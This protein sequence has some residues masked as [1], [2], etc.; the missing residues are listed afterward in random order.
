MGILN[1]FSVS[2]INAGFTTVLVGFASSVVIVFQAATALGASEAQISSWILALGLG[3]GIPGVLLSIYYRMPITVAWSTSGAAVILTSAAGATLEQAVGA[4]IVCALLTI[5][6]G[7]TGWFER[8]I[9]RIPNSIASAMLAGILLRFGLD[10]FNSINT[11]TLLVVAML[12]AYLVSKRIMPRYAVLMPLLVGILIT[13]VEGR[14]DIGTVDLQLSAPVFVPPEFSLSTIL[15]LGIPLFFVTMASQNV[16]GYTVAKNAGFD[17]PLSPVVGFIG[18]CT[19]LLAPFGAFALNLAT[20]TAAICLGEEAHKEKQ[21]RYTAGIAAGLFY[22]LV[23]FFGATVGA[24][25][26]VLPSELVFGIAGIALFSST[27]NALSMS[28][29]HAPD[30]DVAIITFL[31]T[32]SGL[33]LF[34]LGAAFWGLIVGVSAFL[35]LRVDVKSALGN[36]RKNECAVKVVQDNV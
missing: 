21:K 36:R 3:M 5:L 6:F 25:L 16:P 20:L 24:L 34:N 12:L 18:V 9:K 28:M 35:I 31:A 29:Q 33:T 19:L 27:A 26:K 2:S 15:S 7:Y 4:F 17:L 14:T 22:I 1:D 30:R 11:S 23:G 10:V 32:A 13:I 8:L